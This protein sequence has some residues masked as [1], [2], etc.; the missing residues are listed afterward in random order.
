MPNSRRH[1]RNKSSMP[2]PNKINPS[3]Y[4][5]APAPALAAPSPKIASTLPLGSCRNQ[6]QSQ[7]QTQTQSHDQTPAALVA[8]APFPT[9]D[10]NT[11]QTHD[12]TY[13]Q[14]HAPSPLKKIKTVPMKGTEQWWSRYQF[15]M[16]SWDEGQE[17]D[18]DKDEVDGAEGWNWDRNLGKD[19]GGP[20][21]WINSFSWG[22]AP[23]SRGYGSSFP[24]A[25][26][27]IPPGSRL[28]EDNNIP[29]MSVDALTQLAVEV[30]TELSRKRL[31]E[32]Q[33]PDVEKR[34]MAEGDV[35]MEL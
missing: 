11:P 23:M 30:V 24:D 25:Y 3:P 22:G 21:E 19:N 27:S 1:R 35:S 10:L 8:Q 26:M 6:T 18:D 12:D 13:H 16:F 28:N 17:F 14:P 7:G 5:H 33:R 9:Q 31:E 32:P 2:K 29:G 4:P 15:Q 20:K 34:K